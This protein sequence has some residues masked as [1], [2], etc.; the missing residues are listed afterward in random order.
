LSIAQEA[1][2]A[3]KTKKSMGQSKGDNPEDYLYKVGNVICQPGEHILQAIIKR[4]GSY[5]IQ[6]KGKRSYSEMGKDSIN[7]VPDMIPH[8]NQ[9]W[10]VDTRTVVIKATKGRIVRCRPLFLEWSLDFTVELIND[11]LPVEVIKAALDDAGREGG[12]G[13]FRPRFG[14]FIVTSFKELDN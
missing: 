5:K 2:L 11:E 8:N 12:I 3:S 9:N 1:Q 4:L 14:R 6:G 10:V 13:D 7:I